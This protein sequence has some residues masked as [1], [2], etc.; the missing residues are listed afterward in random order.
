LLAIAILFSG[1]GVF[2]AV[3]WMS[4]PPP[5]SASVNRLREGQRAFDRRDYAE[6]ERIAGEILER[7]AE[8]SPALLLAG[9][10][11]EAQRKHREAV[12]YL[13]RIPA[14]DS[15]ESLAAARLGSQ[16]AMQTGFA[17]DAER[18]LRRILQREPDSLDANNRLAY[19]LGVQGR[20]WEARPFLMK[21]VELGRPTVHHLVMLSAS[22]PVVE[23]RKLLARFRETAPD[24]PIFLLGPART[25]LFAGRTES[26]VRAL[27]QIVQADPLSIE[28]QAQLG[29]AFAKA[30]DAERF[31]TWHRN[32]PENAT[33]HPDVWVARGV[34]A[35]R[36]QQT[37]EAARCFWE[38]VQRDPNHR[39]ACHHLAR[40]LQKLGRPRDAN[41]FERRASKLRRLAGAAERV[42][43][44]P[45]NTQFLEEASQL[46]ESLGRHLEAA[47]WARTAL[48]VRQDLVWARNTLDRLQPHFTASGRPRQQGRNLAAEINLAAYPVPDWDRAR[49]SGNQA[50][51]IQGGDGRRRAKIRFVDDAAG[52]GLEF[53]YFNG[54]RRDDAGQWI[55]ESMGGGVAVL[56][57]DGDDRPD[58]YFTQGTNWPVQPGNARHIDALFRNLGDGRFENVTAAAGLGD[59][60]YSH[61]CTVGDF[62]GDG[63][64]DLYVANVGRNRLYRNNG[65]GTF[66]DATDE[67]GLNDRR[68]TTSCLLADVNGDGLPD[69][70][71]VNYLK[72]DLK[73]L[74]F[75]KTG[76]EQGRCGPTQFAAESD[77][78]FLNLGD[79]R[80]RNAT[81]GS[82]VDR[83]NGKGLGI[84]AVDLTGTGRLDLFVAN[85]TVPNFLF[86]RTSSPEEPLQFREAAAALG[87]A[88]DGDGLAQACMGVAVGDANGDGRFDFFITNYADQSNTLYLQENGGTF[89][90][91]TRAAGLRGPS[92]PLLGF[93][94]QFLDADLDG[95]PDLVLTNGH[96]YEPSAAMVPQ[97]FRNRGGGRFEELKSND[98]GPYF[99][100]KFVGRGLARLDW[101]RDGRPDFVVSHTDAP[102][103]LLTNRTKNAGNFLAI[104]LRGVDG[105]RDAIGATVAVHAGERKWVEQLTAGDGYHASN[106]REVV[107]G[108]GRTDVVDRVVVKWPSGRRQEFDATPAGQRFIVVEGRERMLPLGGSAPGRND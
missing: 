32:L 62:N 24:D 93:G 69:L 61:G 5:A 99:G 19:L 40:T 43:S 81:A 10:A 50:V 65:D 35:Q 88:V 64:P 45:G 30:G 20:S 13:K 52:A 6:A 56:D 58:L 22:E 60:D 17:R 37:P 55:I 86:R 11:A 77:Q 12:E 34:F 63:F 33:R 42:F 41:P 51:Q 87:L 31:L 29:L 102:V 59:V 90:D 71:D 72:V 95:R 75:C 84:V 57:Y 106:Q 108:L 2:A 66:T 14:E 3:W 67:A 49:G 25:D 96:V 107:F 92:F 36:R 46:T 4:Q 16:L 54:A 27:E 70:Y 103:A 68:W 39:A 85:D 28:A 97:F 83:P 100:K 26:A 38:A 76:S 80:F 101:N 15:D 105:E 53:S 21:V 82:G 1:A 18:F 44:S 23:D 74:D 94:T 73:N 91:G 78:I 8:S 7:D 48:I 79:G 89:Y 9:R 47:A 104:Q 98:V